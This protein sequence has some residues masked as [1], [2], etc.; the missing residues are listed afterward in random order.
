MA[1][2]CAEPDQK[3][4]LRSPPAPLCTGDDESRCLLSDNQ[5]YALCI[6]GA[7]L[8]VKGRLGNTYVS[9]LVI[10]ANPA[11]NSLPYTGEWRGRAA[12]RQAGG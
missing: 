10:N 8:R 9:E 2:T 12:A 3:L 4:T 5:R 1:L 11:Q 6:A 7:R